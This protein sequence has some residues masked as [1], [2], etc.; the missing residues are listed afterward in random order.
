M[1][2]LFR[3]QLHKEKTPDLS[4]NK[5]DLIQSIFVIF[6]AFFFIDTNWKE[7]EYN[8]ENK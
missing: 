3:E 1:E 4:W 8:K 5:G 6:S 7:S 2:Y